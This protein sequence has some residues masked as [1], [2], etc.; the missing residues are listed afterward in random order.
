MGQPTFFGTYQQRGR[1]LYAEYTSH[2]P[3]Q[4]SY[5]TSAKVIVVAPL[6]AADNLVGKSGD[7]WSTP[8]SQFRLGFPTA[9]GMH[10][11]GSQTVLLRD[12]AS[13]ILQ[14]VA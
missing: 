9:Q 2:A 13:G 3:G 8:Q 4:A 14:L 12:D 10:I 1:N 7:V 11:V 5:D 6:S